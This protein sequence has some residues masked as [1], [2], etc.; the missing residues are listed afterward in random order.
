MLFHFLLMIVRTMEAAPAIELRGVDLC[1]G[2]TTVLQGVD[3]KVQGH[4]RWAV[5]GPNGSGKTTLV[6]IVA[7]YLHPTHGEAH[8][9]GQ[10]LGRCDVRSLRQKLAIVSA[11]VARAVIPWLSASEVILSGKEGALEPWWH[12]YNRADSDRAGELLAASGYGHIA[13]RE[14]GQLSEGERQQV[15]LARA[16]MANPELILMDEPCAGLDMGG[17]ERLLIRLSDLALTSGAPPIVMVTHHVE[18][19]PAGFSHV[20]LLKQG[21]VLAAGPISSTLSAR[22]LSAC[23]DLPLELRHE[24][25]RWTSTSPRKAREYAP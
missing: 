10:W 7:G 23:F 11:S 24:Q 14:F 22:L 20:L 17:R 9:L 18:E 15:L 2:A 5:L 13:D 1:H 12:R 4:E 3:W 6:R 25:G 19:I 16:L 21:R 8:I